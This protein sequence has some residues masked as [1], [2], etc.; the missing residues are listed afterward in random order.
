MRVAILGSRGYPSTYG[1]YETLVRYLVADWV[2]RGHDVTVYCRFRSGNKRMWFVDGVRCIWTPGHESKALSTLSFGGTSHLDAAFRKYDAI[3]VLNVANGFY[4]PLMRALR[5]P[6]AVNTDGIE[7]ERGKWGKIARRV[8]YWG[9]ALTARFGDVLV[10]DSRAMGRV[11]ERLFG[12]ESVF[13]PYGAPVLEHVGKGRI[14]K[15]GLRERAYVLVVARLIPENNVEMALEALARMPER[16]QA[17]IAGSA[18]SDS[19]LEDRLRELNREG[20]VLWLGHVADQELLAELWANCGA[21]VHGHS[22]GGTNP[23]LLQ[24]LGAGAP[25]IALDTEFNREVI[26]SDEQLFPLDA[27][28]LARRLTALL[29]DPERQSR[30]TAHGRAVVAGR[31]LWSQVSDAYLAAI[32]KA[33][34]RRSTRK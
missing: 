24:A 30:F 19:P 20:H 17:V 13:I 7:W 18:N 21:Y 27:E 31:Y 29:A 11:W 34:E 28:E 14:T 33:Q 3:L 15:L 8:F 1:G 12:V 32:E 16:C 25:T 5:V 22:V 10:A 2:D 9:A 4:L 26:D 6:T 23:G